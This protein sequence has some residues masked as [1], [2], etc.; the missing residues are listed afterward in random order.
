MIELAAK[1]FRDAGVNNITLANRTIR[2]AEPLAR[3]VQADIVSLEQLQEILP[4]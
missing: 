2:N 1:Q 3:S 4:F